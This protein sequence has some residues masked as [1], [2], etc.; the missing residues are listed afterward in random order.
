MYSAFF[1]FQFRLLGESSVLAVPALS[2]SPSFNC[3]WKKKKTKTKTKT[4]TKRSKV[5]EGAVRL[6]RQVLRLLT[7]RKWVCAQE[8]PTRKSFVLL[9]SPTYCMC[10]LYRCKVSSKILSFFFRQA[11]PSKL[12]LGR[13]RF[14]PPLILYTN[15]V[16]AIRMLSL[17]FPQTVCR[18]IS[19]A[20]AGCLSG[21]F[22]HCGSTN[23]G[24]PC[25]CQ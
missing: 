16:S 23:Q 14:S 21:A 19:Y 13:H 25:V 15:P 22:R 7:A 3:V 4:K 2:P 24:P 9:P 1:L 12:R 18:I 8:L 20:R 5:C 10:S 11:Q 6:H 17:F